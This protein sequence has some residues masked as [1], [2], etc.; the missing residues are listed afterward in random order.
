VV[1][2]S[3]RAYRRSGS[4]RKALS[5][6]IK[7]ELSQASFAISDFIDVCESIFSFDEGGQREINIV[8]TVKF[9][10]A[11]DIHAV[12]D[13]IDFISVPKDELSDYKF[14]SESLLIGI[15]EWMEAGDA[16]F[17]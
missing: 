16:F 11:S 10:D 1:F 2:P 9:D 7:E 12:E 8:F 3:W 13:H 17:K 6:E 15:I 4:T 5:C 14:L